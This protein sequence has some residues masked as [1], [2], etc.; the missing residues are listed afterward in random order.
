MRR[1][2]IAIVSLLGATRGKAGTGPAPRCSM[3]RPMERL[4][5]PRRERRPS[6]A[7]AAADPAGDGALGPSTVLAPTRFLRPAAEAAPG[8]P[9][10][11][12]RRSIAEIARDGGIAP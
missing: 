7:W 5:P 11:D 10:C 8:P 2:S 1:I 4:Q 9:L 12:G 6:A 3:A